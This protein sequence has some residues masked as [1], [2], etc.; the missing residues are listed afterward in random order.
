MLPVHSDELVKI[1]WEDVDLI[2]ADWRY[3]V[4]KNRHLNKNKHI[5]PL[6]EQA[7]VPNLFREQHTRRL[8]ARTS[9]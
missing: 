2:S 8:S 9:A 1:R 6:P 5:V 4:S 7:L 3:V